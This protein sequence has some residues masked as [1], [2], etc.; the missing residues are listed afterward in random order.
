MDL[1]EIEEALTGQDITGTDAAVA[2]ALLLV[3]VALYLV[4]GRLL[5]RAAA[6][7][8]RRV[9]PGLAI[10][11]AIRLAQFLVLGVFVAWAL[12][13]L[14]ADVGW[15][16]LLIVAVLVIAAV[17]AKPLV[18][19]FSS[20]INVATRSAFSVGDEIEVDGV[21]GEVEEI[22]SRST[23][24]R[25]PDGRSVDIPHSELVD[26]TVVVFTAHDERSTS[27]EL[28]VEL[29]TDLPVADEII[30]G[31]LGSVESITRI[32]SIRA[33]SFDEGVALSVG[34]W[35]GPRLA[36][37]SQARDEAVR[38]LKVAL[39]GAGIALA[40]TSTIRIEPAAS[41]PPETDDHLRPA[42]ADPDHQP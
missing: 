9:V 41:Q 6:R 31:A 30:R 25:T 40:P 13:V 24:L 12:T 33:R 1:D 15:L 2:L 21:I 39:D 22:A 35:H 3:G 32:G 27:I 36:E 42:A 5:R 10:D 17:L 14:G 20:S 38:A 26:K 37:A 11:V 34:F 18:D 19:G 16:T 28:T 29:D 8:P 4:I 7:V 23:V